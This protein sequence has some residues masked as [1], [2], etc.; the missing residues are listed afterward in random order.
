MVNASGFLHADPGSNPHCDSGLWSA[1]RRSQILGEK[2][3]WCAPGEGADAALLLSGVLGDGQD[4]CR[5]WL[6]AFRSVVFWVQVPTLAVR[7]IMCCSPHYQ[8]SMQ[9]PLLLVSIRVA[10]TLVGV[11]KT[12]AATT[13]VE[14]VIYFG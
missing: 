13:E 2:G 11:K 3:Q 6:S 10:K 5:Q 9:V 8:T 12:H 4:A 7:R 14:M 1:Q